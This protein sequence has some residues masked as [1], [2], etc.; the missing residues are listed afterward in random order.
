MEILENFV[1]DKMYNEYAECTVYYKFLSRGISL[2]KKIGPKIA[3]NFDESEP[4]AI[5]K[6]G[7]EKKINDKKLEI[8]L[9]A[10][11]D[12]MTEIKNYGGLGT[13]ID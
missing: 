1:F 13:L 5:D 11:D 2:I 7:I 6:K 12:L 10:T 9:R 3:M 8:I 4:I